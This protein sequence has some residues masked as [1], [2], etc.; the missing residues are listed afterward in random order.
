MWSLIKCARCYSPVKFIDALNFTGIGVWHNRSA[1][2]KKKK[3][4][5]AH[6][7]VLCTYSFTDGCPIR[8]VDC[9]IRVF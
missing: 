5:S 3:F 2:V 9:S 7:L 4:I 6:T 1:Q 8:V